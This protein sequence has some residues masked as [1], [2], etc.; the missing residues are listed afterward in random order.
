LAASALSLHAGLYFINYRFDVF[1][2]LVVL[3]KADSVRVPILMYHH[4]ED[5]GASDIIIS[6]DMFESHIK[7]LSDAGYTSVTFDDLCAFVF[8]GAPLPERPVVITTDDGYMSVY[9][10][11]YP[12]LQRYNM[13]ATV[14]VIGVMHG[15]TF[16]KDTQYPISPP[17]F[18]DAEGVE[19]A[20]SGVISI[21]S[22]SYDMHQNKFYET[23]PFRL[24]V[25]QISGESLED[26]IS[27]FN[28][29]FERSAVQ[30]ENMTGER[31]F[32]YSYPFGRYS[33]LS[34]NLLRDIG[35]KATLTI[36]KGSSIITAGSPESLFGLKRYNISGKMSA[37][38]LLSLIE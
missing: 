4:F 31:P 2:R 34:E 30:I 17:H 9:D 10:I 12:I 20:D 11:A 6:S 36:K 32:V 1:S 24:G 15:E 23:G 7:A 21:Q 14:F 13:K 22:H 26:Y 16:Y 37:D 27:A 28:A 18:G 33:K 38:K 3:L 25:L 5:D 29:D 35:V 19:M 8:D